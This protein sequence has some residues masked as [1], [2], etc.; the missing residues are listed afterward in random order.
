MARRF[1]TQHGGTLTA[2]EIWALVNEPSHPLQAAA[3]AATDEYLEWFGRA[4]ALILNVLDPDVVVLGGGLSKV[5]R[6][7]TEGP[8]RV[9]AHLFSDRLATP[10]RRPLLGD[11]AGVFGAA[12]LAAAPEAIAG[13]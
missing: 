12:L 8:A 6:L 7:Y 11:A 13:A 9:A 1:A 4:M 5:E 3:V 10:I 2:E